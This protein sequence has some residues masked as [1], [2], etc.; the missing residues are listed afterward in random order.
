MDMDDFDATEG[1]IQGKNGAGDILQMRTFGNA[2]AAEA[3]DDVDFDAVLEEEDEE[4]DNAEARVLR[5]TQGYLQESIMSAY[6]VLTREGVRDTEALETLETLAKNIDGGMIVRDKAFKQVGLSQLVDF[7]LRTDSDG[8]CA[9]PLLRI[10]NGLTCANPELQNMLGLSEGIAPVARFIGSS[11]QDV[12]MQVAVFYSQLYAT[13]P[14]LFFTCGGCG[15]LVKLLYKAYKVFSSAPSSASSPSSSTSTSTTTTTSSSSSQ[16]A[17]ARS[18]HHKRTA[19]AQQLRVAGQDSEGSEHTPGELP[20]VV[21][22]VILKTLEGDRG[23]SFFNVA[24]SYLRNE[25]L[26]TLREA[27]QALQEDAEATKLVW[28]VALMMA[29]TDLVVKRAICEPN[30][31]RCMLESARTGPWD[32]RVS[33]VKALE[34]VSCD[35]QNIERLAKEGAISLLV[36]QLQATDVSEAT[37]GSAA[38]TGAAIAMAMGGGS[39]KATAVAAA[40][41]A[42]G[43]AQRKNMKHHLLITLSNIVKLNHDRQAKLL[44]LGIVPILC[45]YHTEMPFLNDVIVPL[46]CDL[47]KAARKYDAFAESEAYKTFFALLANPIYS[48]RAIEC[49][50]LWAKVKAIRSKI[51]KRVSIIASAFT[52]AAIEWPAFLQPLTSIA[53]QSHTFSTKVWESKALPLAILSRLPKASPEQIR[54]IVDLLGTVYKKAKGDKEAL[55]AEYKVLDVLKKTRELNKSKVVVESLIDELIKTFE[56]SS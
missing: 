51:C 20:C 22:R 29:S 28:R 19:H 10:I 23:R 50:A 4:E 5:E 30:F 24:R 49:L 48:S 14:A 15:N 44:K 13:T 41:A 11:K 56:S 26:K 18:Q 31:V 39:S 6:N 25:L 34:E 35:Q 37:A 8:I 12:L 2:G 3:V 47:F 54:L 32:A 43:D 36:K 38:G 17:G 33:I 52:A 7:L 45:K 1:F 16:L 21:L 9:A 55:A 40:A 27:A 46:L 53:T 42:A